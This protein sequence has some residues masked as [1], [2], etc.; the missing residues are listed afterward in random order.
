MKK[1]LIITPYRDRAQH[2]I[3]WEP[4]MQRTMKEQDINAEIIVVCQDDG[5]PF[6][7]AMLLNIGFAFT[8]G[9]ADYYCLADVDMLPE[10][11]DYSYVEH[12][13]HLAARCSQFDY[14]LPYHKYFGGITLINREDF[15]TINGLSN[16]Y[17]SPSCE[18]DDF[19]RRCVKKGLTPARRNCQFRSLPHKRWQ[20]NLDKN[21]YGEL[22]KKLEN[23][24]DRIDTDGL[25]SLRY[26]VLYFE[27][28]GGVT[29]IIVEI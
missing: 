18:D 20:E 5:K 28:G 14:K 6:N 15:L 29:K 23:C 12:P 9:Q 3:E 10:I 19:F 13:T 7:R 24:E 22:L 27:Q 26:K 2:L 11:S 16:L 1:L 4:A 17:T 25:N 8:E 21:V